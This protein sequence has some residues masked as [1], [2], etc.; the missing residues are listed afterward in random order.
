MP[1]KNLPDAKN[2]ILKAAVQVF[3]EKGLEGSRID[4]ISAAA[5][6]PKSLIYYHF[7]SKE[8]IFEVMVSNFINEFKEISKGFSNESH[9]QKA[10]SI[11]DK[12]WTNYR[13]YIL[14][15]KDL[16]R[17]I[18]IESFKK[19]SD[20]PLIYQIAEAFTSSFSEE[21]KLDKTTRDELITAEFFTNVLPN[22]AIVCFSDTF[23]AHFNIEKTQLLNHYSKI[24]QITHGAYHKSKT[25]ERGNY[26]G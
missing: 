24:I 18:M 19:S 3:A 12:L 11:S 25:I 1:R 8:E 23:S 2:R 13:E 20:K 26:N 14:E 4:Q 16:V 9:E 10:S 5:N 22:L 21:M 7:Q 15:N 17:I 6:V